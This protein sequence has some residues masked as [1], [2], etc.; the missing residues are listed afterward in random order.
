MKVSGV[1]LQIFKIIAA[2]VESIGKIEAKN[3][4]TKMPKKVKSKN[5][6]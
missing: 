5:F 4:K 1:L 6:Y 3:S 2:V